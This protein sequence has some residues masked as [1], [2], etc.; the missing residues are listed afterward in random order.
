L[1]VVWQ[2]DGSGATRYLFATSVDGGG[3][4]GDGVL[5]CL[6]TGEHSFD[7]LG[8][9]FLDAGVRG[10]RLSSETWV[11]STTS[12]GLAGEDPTTGATTGDS[13]ASFAWD[14]VTFVEGAAAP[15]TLDEGASKEIGWEGDEPMW[16]REATPEAR[17]VRSITTG[18]GEED[19][20]SEPDDELTLLR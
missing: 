7:L 16:S 13:Q 20:A 8:D 18:D 17:S 4:K 6:I 1:E 9:G 5:L 2:L 15:S 19:S 12:I 3:N 11:K 10:G 14:S